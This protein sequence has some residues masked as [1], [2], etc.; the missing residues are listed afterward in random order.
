ME[1]KKIQKTRGYNRKEIHPLIYAEN[2]VM[3]TRGE[4]GEKQYRS[5]GGRGENYWM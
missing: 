1:S 5:E 4:W 2:K 3:V